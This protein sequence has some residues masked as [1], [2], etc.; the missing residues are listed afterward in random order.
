MK[1]NTR[2][3]NR[4]RARKVGFRTRSKTRGGRRIIK[5][6]RQKSGKFRVG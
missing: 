3:S 6:K 2:R 5:R 1:T 4:K